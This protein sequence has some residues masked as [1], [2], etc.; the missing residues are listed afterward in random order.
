MDIWIAALLGVIVG[1]VVGVIIYWAA[2]GDK[3]EREIQSLKNEAV[4]DFMKRQLNINASLINFHKNQVEINNS[5]NNFNKGQ[6]ETNIAFEHRIE[7]MTRKLN[8]LQQNLT[9]CPK[10]RDSF[11]QKEENDQ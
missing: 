2:S 9:F 5:L 4:K 10:V 11:F 8:A 3:E 6:I 1:M 7:T